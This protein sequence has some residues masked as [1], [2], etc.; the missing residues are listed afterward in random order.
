MLSSRRAFATSARSTRLLVCA[1]A[2]LAARVALPSM[3]GLSVCTALEWMDLV[4]PLHR[5]S[6]L[7]LS[8]STGSRLA[9]PR[10]AASKRPRSFPR[11]DRPPVRVCL[12]RVLG[13]NVYSY[14]CDCSC[15]M[16]V[17]L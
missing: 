11:Q 14:H 8:I 1:S 3:E 5:V 17:T 12:P 15:P 13:E 2:Q 4:Q 7:P 16:Y 9:M 10:M 6:C